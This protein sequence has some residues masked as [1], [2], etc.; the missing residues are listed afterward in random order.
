[1]EQTKKSNPKGKKVD[2][3]PQG[4]HTVTPSLMV[5][6]ADMLI[7]FIKKAFDGEVTSMYKSEDGKIMH[8]TV[9]I[10]NSIVMIGDANEK[11]GPITSMLHLYVNDCDK[12]YQQAL[13]AKGTS[14]R[15]PKNEF[16][17][18][19]SGCVQDAWG[20]Q[21]WISTHVE[22]VDDEEMQKRMK[23]FEAHAQEA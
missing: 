10:G 12:V 15:E 22:D 23:E 18:D 20:N 9:Q 14:I 2:P 19:R 8:A 13:K 1:M 6:Q 16:Y 7:E 5:S 21:W 17:G 11:Y 3:I 4:Y